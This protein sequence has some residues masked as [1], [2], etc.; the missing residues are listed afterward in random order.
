MPILLCETNSGTLWGDIFFLFWRNLDIYKRPKKKHLV[1]FVIY[2]PSHVP[3]PGFE[4]GTHTWKVNNLPTKLTRQLKRIWKQ[5]FFLH[6][7]SLI[8]NWLLI[9]KL[10]KTTQKRGTVHSSACVPSEINR[11]TTGPRNNLSKLPIHGQYN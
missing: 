2:L 4:P 5:Q 3:T 1:S 8:F 9:D 7:F 6:F 11:K 10:L